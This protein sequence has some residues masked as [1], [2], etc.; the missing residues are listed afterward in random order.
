MKLVFVDGQWVVKPTLNLRQHQYDMATLIAHVDDLNMKECVNTQ[1]LT[2]EFCVKYVLNE[3]CVAAAAAFNESGD[4]CRV[5][6]NQ[7]RRRV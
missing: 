6:E 2:A 7:Q 4:F 5:C 1:V 3:E